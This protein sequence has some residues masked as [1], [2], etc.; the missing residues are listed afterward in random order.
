MSD[1][2]HFRQEFAIRNLKTK[3][4]TLYPA[5]A[6]VVRDIHNVSIQPGQNQ[7][8]ITGLT[9]TTDENSIK[10]DGTG[11]AVITNLTVERVANPEKF[12]DIYPPEDETDDETSDDHE[13][14]VEESA[15]RKSLRVE[16]ENMQNNDLV[17]ENE[18]IASA[19]NRLALLDKHGNSIDGEQ[20]PQDVEQFL[21]NYKLAR[22]HIF[23]DHKAATQE[24]GKLRKRIEVLQKKLAKFDRD[25]AKSNAKAKKENEKIKKKISE[26]KQEKRYKKA[27]T[28]RDL[29][30]FW[31]KKVFKVTV[32]LE[33][34]TTFTPGSSRRNS[35]DSLVKVPREEEEVSE[36]SKTVE[37]SLS[38]S[39]ITSSA[40]WLP[41]YDL[42][43][44][45]VKSQ[46]LLDYCAELRNTTSETWQDARIV[47]S[48]SQT[49]YQGLGEE[50]PK[51]QQWHVRL[52]KKGNNFGN[53]QS[54]TGALYSNHEKFYKTA[55]SHT[56]LHSTPNR[57]ELFG[58]TPPQH[59]S[60]GSQLQ[61][62]EQQNQR[63]LQH[64]RTAQGALFGAS[65]P[66]PA[67]SSAPFALQS[68]QGPFGGSFQQQ[69]QAEQNVSSANP[70][71]PQSMA[72]GGRAR[73]SAALG[74][75]IYEFDE[76]EF[77]GNDADNET[78]M[79]V[80]PALTFEESISQE[81]GLTTTYD[82]PG[83]K[84][85]TPTFIASKHRIA[86]IEFKSV[87]FSHVLVPKLKA[88]A[89]LKAK[90]RN[91]SKLT[92]LK[93]I[94]GLTLDGSFLGQST[95]P[96]CSSGGDVFT[97]SLGIDPSINVSYAKP[98]VRRSQSGIFN[99]EDSE[100]FTRTATITN[101]KNNAV[102]QL[103]V[104]DQIPVSE[105]ERLKID[106]LSPRGLKIGSEAVKAAVSTVSE[107]AST[108]STANLQSAA[109]SSRLSVYGDDGQKVDG[110]QGGGKWGSA[111]AIAKKGGEIDW[112][113]GINAGR[114]CKLV[115]E[116]ETSYPNGESVIAA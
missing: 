33:T 115:L 85:L 59:Q 55:K 97:L 82:L 23:E 57:S 64:S 38:I 3:S 75:D 77:T 34:A 94:A 113:V 61:L 29:E 109:S 37:I 45:S 19:T 39:Y 56:M 6:Q 68:V 89:F 107:A 96:R 13:D 67:M 58:A 80:D 88:A 2:S 31:P 8:I 78:L 111:T 86:R 54:N 44:D 28:R 47:L 36:N 7:I 90:L 98:T 105:D 15:E 79:P 46:G 18:K 102:V 66:A 41:R 16:I 63:R 27:K 32:S 26:A 71:P 106:I 40:S 17:L 30:N 11:S 10:V 83:L 99:K 70:P 5:K 73:R 43:L 81:S 49:T 76:G 104:L 72:P 62:L 22:A 52:A 42:S 110:G 12:D 84:T 35:I 116:Y 69:Q 14:A 95:I 21:K 92:L 93:G 114:G 100:V 20:P 4:V 87:V 91:S 25:V 50:I 65:A 53:G 9:P 51:L 103:T 48:T 108:K 60:F 112:T 101:T 24:A 74:S 1:L